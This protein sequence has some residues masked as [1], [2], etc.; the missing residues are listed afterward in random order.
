MLKGFSISPGFALAKVFCLKHFQ[1][2]DVELRVLETSEI[3]GELELFRQA[4]KASKEEIVN[5]LELP[6]IRGSLEI[7]NIFKAHLTLIDDP[8]LSKEIE[9]RISESKQDV[10]F[11]LTGVIKD[12]SNFFRNLP[13]PQFQ[14][15]AIDI[16]DV[17]RRIL[18]NCQ[19]L[20]SVQKDFSALDEGVIIVA[21]NLTPSEIV[22]FDQSKILGIAISEG[23]PTSH[24]SILARSLGIPAII[25][26]ENI[27]RAMKPNHFAIL[28]GDNGKLIIDPNPETIDKYSK[29]KNSFDSYKI[30]LQKSIA[31]PSITKDNVKISLKA[32]I[33]QL[34]DIDAVIS[35]KAQGVGLYRTEFAYLT[36]R[37]FPTEKELVTSYS[38][39]ISRLNGS[40]VV[41]RT[42]DIGGDKISHLM[43]NA[44][45]RN[46][47]LGWRAVRMALDCEDV[48]CTQ[49]RAILIASSMAAPN[50]VKLLFPMISNLEELRKTK[51]LLR[52]VAK[53][54]RVSEN[55]DV[56]QIDI[57]IMVE[58]PSVALMAEIFAKEVDFFSIGSNDLV[59]YTLAV[60]RT[61]SKV[62]HLYQP[63]NPAI[64]RLIHNVVNVASN[65]N[66]GVSLCGEIAG[67]P[68]YTLL[69]LGLGLRE[70]SMN[71]VLL[72]TIKEIVRRISISE[73][74]N[75]VK[76]LLDLDT[77][78]KIE[79]ELLCI[80]ER[81]KIK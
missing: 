75:L 60:D 67:D 3:K 74:E 46:P 30:E 81:L 5:L 79:K 44:L 24:A 56:K 21:E 66:I 27:E 57:G 38:N 34:S 6:Q 62:S 70:L 65:S 28:D 2:E 58:V 14:G 51:A 61:N 41:I 9:K 43:G 68:K 50:Q 49:L 45:E 47:E 25:Q 33:G 18:K 8:D 54:L 78:E 52:K 36:R 53:D 12:Y 13:D 1:F 40:P 32:N 42:I 11:A 80:N 17:G 16:V 64:L 20:D 22:T 31:L 4:I 69:L 35:N 63:T 7:S 10:K 55:V 59:Q 71:A 72:P 19:P 29:L 77:S 23:T 48:F 73:V 15:K 37:T 39:V 76:P 26:L